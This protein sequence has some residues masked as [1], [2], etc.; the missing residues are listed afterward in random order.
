MC[1][2]FFPSLP[3]YSKVGNDVS[4][5]RDGLWMRSFFVAFVLLGGLGGYGALGTT[6]NSGVL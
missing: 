3:Q 2:C 4:S 1:D 6:R 5:G